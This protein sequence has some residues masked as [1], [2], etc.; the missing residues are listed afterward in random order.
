MTEGI[1]ATLDLNAV[2][3]LCITCV[4][5]PGVQG[6]SCL[7]SVEEVKGSFFS[8][9]SIANNGTGVGSYCTPYLPDG[10]YTVAVHENICNT[11]ILSQQ[12][13]IGNS[14]ATSGGGDS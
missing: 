12:V 2:V 1:S 9:D 14:I 4:F 5:A 7:I 8:L 6:Y 3:G 10:I 11:T 13:V